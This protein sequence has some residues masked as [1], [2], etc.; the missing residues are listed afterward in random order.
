M[1]PP[2]VKENVVQRILSTW[3]LGTGEDRKGGTGLH[4]VVV[5]SEEVPGPANHVVAGELGPR[6]TVRE[7]RIIPRGGLR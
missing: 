6:T 5:V 4:G 2:I 1:T 3:I 7:F